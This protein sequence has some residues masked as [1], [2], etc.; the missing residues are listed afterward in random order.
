MKILLIHNKYKEHGGEDVVVDT[1]FNILKQHQQVRLLAFDNAAINSLLQKFLFGFRFFFNRQSASELQKVISEFQP[2]IIHVHNFFYVASPSIFF[3]AKKNKIPIVLTMHNFRLVC[4]GALL[5][6]NHQVCELCIHKKFPASGIVHACH[7][8]SRLR[9]AQLVA[10]NAF[11]NYMGTWKNKVDTYIALTDFAKNKLADSSLGVPADKIIVKSN[12]VKDWTDQNNLPPRENFF[13]FVGRLSPEK[14]IDVLLKAMEQ[15][16]HQL[17][18]IGDGPLREEVEKRIRTRSNIKYW[19]YQEKAFIIERL[20]KASAL[21]FPSIWYEG[22]PNTILE[23]FS[24]GTPIIASDIGN[25]NSI[26]TNN[27]NGL[28]FRTGDPESLLNKINIFSEGSGETKKL[29]DNARTT[30]L[31]KYTEQKSYNALM[32]I[33][34]RTIKKHN[35]RQQD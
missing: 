2:D 23:A 27:Y 18:I 3:T 32:A 12:S 5:L 11:H 29:N 4:A 34:D 6:R 9:T 30:Y 26:V 22:L 8:R 33:Y 20:R 7:G 24:T 21:I 31:E 1:E 25:I 15:T 35:T 14:G 28:L 10:A 13:L 17:E 19:G 16:H